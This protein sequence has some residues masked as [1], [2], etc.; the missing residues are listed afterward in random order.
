[1]TFSRRTFLGSAAASA[2]AA[3]IHTV[4]APA[5]AQSGSVA[6][7]SLHDLSG[8]VDVYGVPSH[9]CMK[10]AIDEINAAGGLLGK[11]IELKVYDAQ[12]DIKK[13]PQYAQQAALQDKVVMLQGAITGASREAARPVL[14]RYKVP[15]VYGTIYEGGL[16]EKNA[17]SVNTGSDQQAIPL[18]EWS[19]KNLGK[20]VFYIGA[21]YNAPRNIGIWT[22]YLASRHGGEVVGEEYYPLDVTEFA[23][24]ISKIQ[25]AKPDYVH[26]CLVGGPHMSFYRQWAAAG[27]LHKIPIVSVVFAGGNEHMVLT[28]EETDGIIVAYNYFQE[29]DTPENK[30]FLKRLEASVG[31]NHPYVNGI[32]IGGYTGPMIWAEAVRKA[33]SFEREKVMAA[34]ADNVEWTGPSGRMITDGRTHSTQQDV[35]IIQVKNR[36]WNLLETR[37]QVPPYDFAGRCDLVANPA[38]TEILTPKI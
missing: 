28:P 35:H 5:V 33:G 11:R 1:M 12:S 37:K 20:K 38:N 26:S 21:D 32:A 6:V 14:R 27:M 22:R 34:F 2:V 8:A 17:I 3:G 16:C 36:K 4:A 30:A 31:G 19:F 13:Y 24:A 10:F 25:A 23:T 15:F 29:L 7:G 18:L 9:M